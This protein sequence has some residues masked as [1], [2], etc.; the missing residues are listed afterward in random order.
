MFINFLVY[1]PHNMKTQTMKQNSLN[2]RLFDNYRD[3]S[4]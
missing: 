4:I 2:K 3:S 1:F